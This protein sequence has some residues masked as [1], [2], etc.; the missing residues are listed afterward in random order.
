MPITYQ[1]WCRSPHKSCWGKKSSC[2][3]QCKHHV[4]WRCGNEYLCT[5][6]IVKLCCKSSICIHADTA[7]TLSANEVFSFVS[8]MISFSA[9]GTLG[10]FIPQI[11]P[12]MCC[13]TLKMWTL[14]RCHAEQIYCPSALLRLS[15]QFLSASYAN[16]IPVWAHTGKWVS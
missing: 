1:W 10:A 3:N 13:K 11:S 9:G 12:E 15:I 2:S 4:S 8:M 14:L 16:S 7:G 5:Y 6:Q